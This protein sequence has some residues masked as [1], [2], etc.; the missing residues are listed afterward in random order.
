[1]IGGRSVGLNVSM[2][3]IHIPYVDLICF[4]DTA[5]S[6]FGTWGAATGKGHG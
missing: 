3:P 5:G 2:T 1:M 4:S 6:G